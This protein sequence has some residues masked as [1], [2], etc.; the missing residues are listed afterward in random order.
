MKISRLYCNDQNIMSRHILFNEGINFIL[1]NGHDVGK[2]V[3]FQL[4]DWCLLK[5]SKTFLSNSVF[6]E[7][8]DLAFFLEIKL[9]NQ[10]CTIKR[11]VKSKKIFI[12]CLQSS[13]DLTD[14][15]NDKFQY[16]N[17]NLNSAK[18][19]LNDKMD[20][21]CKPF[22]DYR[23]FLGF[24]MRDQDN[25]SDIFRLNKF[26]RSKDIDWKPYV[27][28]LMGIN[29][30][31]IRQKYELD[32][33]IDKV[34]TEIKNLEKG[35]SGETQEHIQ[36][37]IDLLEQEK[38]EFEKSFQKFDFYLRE[39]QIDK[40]LVDSIEKNIAHYN[41][42]R[43]ALRQ[44]IAYIESTSHNNTS[45]TIGQID[46]FFKELNVYFNKDLKKQYEDVIYFNEVINKDRKKILQENLQ[47]FKK[48]MNAI[49]E[50]LTDLNQQRK[51]ALSLLQSTDTM[52]KFKQL[53]REIIDISTQISN[54]KRMLEKFNIISDMRSEVEKMKNKLNEN[55]DSIKGQVQNEIHQQIQKIFLQYALIVL[56]ERI[57]ISLGLNI[58]KN[59]D[60]A[61]TFTND[62]KRDEGHTIQKLLC[63]IF[64]MSL[65]EYYENQNF[66]HFIAFD[67]AMDGDKQEYQDRLLNA[68]Q[69]I[70]D[71]NIQ[72]IITTIDDEIKNPKSKEFAEKHSI[73][74]LTT[75]NPLLIPF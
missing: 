28:A 35:L 38:E 54:L 50:C 53:E 4:L 1:A 48:Q 68:L 71:L 26:Q 52:K 70:S 47:E 36:D 64:A 60:F 39:Q 69:K 21:V 32:A 5:D 15:D 65:V 63:F 25:Q 34:L 2:T 58:Q 29:G 23:K 6:Q 20:F 62:E 30:D 8:K 49:D 51:K 56:Q 9:S 74:T 17:L 57:T 19:I 10:Y 42:Q 44:E 41:K 14:L 75:D 72:V 31:L 18:E 37:K 16:V 43:N 66:F 33:T 40:N 59:I 67:S 13:E 45:L 22:G 12:T 61:T 46:D 11:Y 27:V 55:V 24:F 73:T 3:L 7:K